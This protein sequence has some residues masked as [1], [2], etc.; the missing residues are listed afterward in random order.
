MFLWSE[1]HLWKWNLF[2][3]GTFMLWWKRLTVLCSQSLEVKPNASKTILSAQ[4]KV[5]EHPL[6]GIWALMCVWPLI[7][8]WE[9]WNWKFTSRGCKSYSRCVVLVFSPLVRAS[10]TES[11]GLKCAASGQKAFQYVSPSLTS[12]RVCTLLLLVDYCH[13]FLEGGIV[14]KEKKNICHPHLHPIQTH[15]PSFHMS[16]GAI[17]SYCNSAVRYISA[18]CVH[19]WSNQCV[20]LLWHVYICC[21]S[22]NF[23]STFFLF[24]G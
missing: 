6:T 22:A 8:V 3:N 1:T 17:L 13:A 2:V 19:A 4:T 20:C 18:L 7:Y 21:T 12:K 14:E 23:L 15:T 11:R 10:Q 24:N 16:K 5:I 9:D